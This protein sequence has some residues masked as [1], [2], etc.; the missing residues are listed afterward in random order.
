MKQAVLQSW[1][2]VA[3]RQRNSILMGEENPWHEA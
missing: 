3:F 1:E 2:L